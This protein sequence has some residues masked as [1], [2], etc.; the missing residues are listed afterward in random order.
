M[1]MWSIKL[2]TRACRHAPASKPPSPAP[3]LPACPFQF[4]FRGWLVYPI[5]GNKIFGYKKQGFQLQE[6]RKAGLVCG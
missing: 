1:A 4:E 6:T 3:G 5:P 2:A